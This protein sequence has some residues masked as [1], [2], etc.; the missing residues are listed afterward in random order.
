MIEKSTKEI[1]QINDQGVLLANEGKFEEGIKLLRKAVQNLPGNILVI[2][3]L[4]GML[5]GQM[6]QSGK[7][8]R[9]I[10]EARELL[11][12]VRKID[13]ANKKLT[14]YTKLLSQ[15]ASGTA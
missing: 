14:S 13:P 7:D 5:I 1:I 6:T 11:D 12:R 2:T 3:N 9:M 10:Y 8:D 4:C 15:I